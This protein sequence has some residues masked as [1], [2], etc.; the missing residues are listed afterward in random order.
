MKSFLKKSA[1]CSAS[2]LQALSVVGMGVGAIALAAPAAAQDYTRGVLSGT[3]VDEAGAPLAGAEVT[4]TSN[5]QG[6]SQSVTTGS[7]GSFIVPNL[8]TGTYTVSVT[9][10]GTPVVEDRGATVVAGQTNSYRYI[11]ASGDAGAEADGNDIVVLGTRIQ[12]N[13]FAQTQTG[14]TLDVQELASTVPVGRDQTSLIL[15]APGTTAGDSG[16]GNLA[17]I[18]G[19]TVAENAY[20]V[21]GLNITDFRSFLGGSIIPFEFYRTL[22]VK[23]GGYQAEYGRALGGVTSAVTKSGSNEFKAG[24]VATWAPDALRTDSPNTFTDLDSDPTTTGDKIRDKND[25]D[26]RE[27]YDASLYVS[28]PIIKD[29]LFFY[30]LYQP[31]Y[32][33]NGD[34]SN[35]NSLR[36]ETKSKS[37]FFGGKVDFVIADGHRLEGT[38]FR[39]DQTQRTNYFNYDGTTDTVGA[40]RGAVVSEFGGN[41]FIGTYTGQFT[42]WLT[43]SASY[44][45]NHDKATQHTDPDSP[46]LLSRIGTTRIAYGT[47]IGDTNDI[48]DRKFY[49]ADVDVY[50][51]FAGEHHFR[52]GFDYEDLTAGELTQYTGAGFRYDLRT[53]QTRR[54]FYYNQ[55]EFNTN[56][57]AF[58]LQDSWSLMDG[59]LNLQLGIRNDRFKNYTQ[60]GDLYYDSGDQW[61][62][63]LGATFDLFG[64][65]ATKVNAFWGRYFLPI[66][67]NTNIRLAGAELYVEQRQTYTAAAGADADGDGVPDFYTFDS[68]GNITN[69]APNV[70]GACPA[71]FQTLTGLSQQCA[72]IFADGTQGPTDTLVAQ[73]LAPSYSDEWLLGISHRTGDWKFGL[74]YINRRLGETLEDVAI[75]AAVNAYCAENG[76]AGCSSVF[77]GFHQYVLSNPGSPITVRL[78]GDCSVAGMCDIVTL[79]VAD[80]GYPKAERAYDA[81]QFTVDKAFNGVYGFNFSYTWTNLVGNFEGGVKSDNNQTDTGLTQDFDQPGFLDGAYGDLANGR[82]H[83]FKLYGHV[84]PVEWLDIG[85]NALVESPRKFSCIGNYYDSSNFAASY[86]AASYYCQQSNVGGTAVGGSYLVPRGSAFESEWN[87]Q[88][89]LRTSFDLGSFTGLDGSYFALDVFNVFNWKSKLDFDEFGDV[90]FGGPNADFMKVR[91]YQAPRSVRLTLAVRFGGQ[92]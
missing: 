64:D 77:S 54:R 40:L 32:F 53:T 88:I 78:D 27:S 41:N 49:R 55:G 66:A 29:R 46:Y 14:L 92:P 65:G 16:F 82:A 35:S 36:L 76:I 90:S 4:V 7:N 79:D 25:A 21:N 80:L 67:T 17:S 12:V 47:V 37:P 31:R 69:Y 50:A 15:L 75:D 71:A 52:G 30:A 3:V 20:Y 11:A 22:D 44:G 19:A 56:M 5:S 48:N 26:Y 13:D 89:D 24:V 57:R 60:S 18:G 84:K 6:F 2:C 51:N 34:T 87:K 70:G 8:P 83:V 68:D 9:A 58:Y 38:F 86:G 43:L 61:G 42:D 91:G 85:V 73:G 33:K 63:R 74:S 10:N 23:T 45:E 81:I 39:D 72:I 62:P 1:L 28:G 59:R